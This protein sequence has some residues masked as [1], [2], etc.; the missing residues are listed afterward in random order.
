MSLDRQDLEEA[1]VSSRDMARVAKA[2]Y[3]AFVEAGFTDSQ[4][5]LLL[6]TWLTAYINLSGPTST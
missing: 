4:A 2:Q 5:L 1:A 3:D 6:R